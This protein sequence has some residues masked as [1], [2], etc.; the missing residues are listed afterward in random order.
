MEKK[1]F[2]VFFLLVPIISITLLTV[3]KMISRSNDVWSAF[4]SSLPIIIFYYL[5]VSVFWVINLDKM[6]ET[7]SV[8]SNFTTDK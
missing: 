2:S 6:K 3:F 4:E 5:I 7:T 1:I 8:K